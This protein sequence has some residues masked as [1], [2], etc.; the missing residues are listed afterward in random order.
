[1]KVLLINDTTNWYHF[2]CTATSIALIERIEKLGHLVTPLPITETY[3]IKSAPLTKAEFLDQNKYQDFA[4]N[5]PELMQLI[6]Q[7]DVII[8]NGEGTLHGI[9]PAPRSLLY[10]A[11]IA[12]TVFA[13]HVEILN[14]SAYPEHDAFLGNTEEASIYKLVYDIID[15]AAI[16]EPVSFSVMRNLSTK[17][18]ESFDCAPLYIRDHYIRTNIKHSNELLIAGSATWLELNIA[19]NA[20]GNIDDFTIGLS[21][22]N[23]YLQ[24]MSAQ[25]FKIKFLYGAKAFPAKDD[26][27]FIE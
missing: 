26:Q 6:A 18:L 21:G 13:K 3:K 25:G 19:S 8:I 27:E 17:I 12:K 14:H 11:Y 23:H 4:Q 16:R 1:M 24:E 15:F 2:G 9:T 7:H 5:N 20:R 10:S 22:L